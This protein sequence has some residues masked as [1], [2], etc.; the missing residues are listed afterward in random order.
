MHQQNVVANEHLRTIANE[1]M[2]NIISGSTL[3]RTLGELAKDQWPV[4]IHPSIMYET[5]DAM[6]RIVITPD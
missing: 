6:E 3:L 4:K 1:S 5:S 2:N